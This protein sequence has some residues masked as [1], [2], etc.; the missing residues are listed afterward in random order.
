M[1]S[2]KGVAGT[3]PSSVT[4]PRLGCRVVK[5][6]CGWYRAVVC[7]NTEVGMPCCQG[8]VWLVQSRRL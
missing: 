2:R 5:E 8:G 7:D 3:E 1:L 4:T 6:G